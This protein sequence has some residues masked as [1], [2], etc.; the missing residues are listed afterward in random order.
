MAAT[1]LTIDEVLPRLLAGAVGSSELGQHQQLHYVLQP[2]E[3]LEHRCAARLPQGVAR[4][5]L[6]GF[7]QQWGAEIVGDSEDQFVLRLGLPGSFWQRCL[8]AQPGLEV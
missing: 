2:G 3:L 1:G 5:K 8:G 6:D 7:V 4:L